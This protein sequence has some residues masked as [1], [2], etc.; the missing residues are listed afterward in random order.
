MTVGGVL[1]FSYAFL[2]TVVTVE[3]LSGAKRQLVQVLTISLGILPFLLFYFSSF[4]PM[5]MVLTALL[6]YLFDLFILPLLCLVFVY[7]LW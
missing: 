5:S 2:L 4:N 1:T 3:E 6:S 7:P